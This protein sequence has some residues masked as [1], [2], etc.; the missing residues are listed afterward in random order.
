MWL[1]EC[2]GWL[3]LRRVLGQHAHLAFHVVSLFLAIRSVIM[4]KEWKGHTQLYTLYTRMLC[5]VICYKAL[6]FVCV[7]VLWFVIIYVKELSSW[8]TSNSDADASPKLHDSDKSEGAVK[9]YTLWI[10]RGLIWAN[11]SVIN[12]S[13]MEPTLFY[14]GQN[15]LVPRKNMWQM[16]WYYKHYHKNIAKA[17]IFRTKILTSYFQNWF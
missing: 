3:V 2:K 16:I 9:E 1:C 13:N 4:K 7:F 10:P 14:L 11:I 12:Q 15:V 6:H 5:M 8:L 17:F